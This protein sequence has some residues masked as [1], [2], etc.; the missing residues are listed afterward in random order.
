MYKS[1][2]SFQWRIQDLNKG[3][4]EFYENEHGV[5]NSMMVGGTILLITLKALRKESEVFSNLK[6]C[7]TTVIHNFK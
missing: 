1:K 7:L 4:G 6:L 2:Y 3:G 5:E